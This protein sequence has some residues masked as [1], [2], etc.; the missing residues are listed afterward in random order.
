MSY[1]KITNQS[2]HIPCDGDLFDCN[3]VG[4]RLNFDVN[5]DVFKDYDISVLAGN[6]SGTDMNTVIK[7]KIRQHE[8]CYY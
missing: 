8:H 1:S 2:S 5:K 3:V 4:V 7:G 6:F